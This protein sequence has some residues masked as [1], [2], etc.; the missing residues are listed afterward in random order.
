M[1]K[2][3]AADAADADVDATSEEGGTTKNTKKTVLRSL[4]VRRKRSM[5]MRLGIRVRR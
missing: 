5:V 4:Q 1:K 3:V 2:T